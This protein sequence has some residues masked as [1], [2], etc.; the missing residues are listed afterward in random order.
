MTRML[1]P[2]VR[3]IDSC[4]RTLVWTGTVWAARADLAETDGESPS[5]CR[6]DACNPSS[7]RR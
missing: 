2:P 5:G 7:R 4:V 3:L 1:P 6:R